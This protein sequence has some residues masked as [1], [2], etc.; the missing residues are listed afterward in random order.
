MKHLSNESL[1]SLSA[2]EYGDYLLSIGL[3]Y[4]DFNI[5]KHYICAIEYGDYSGLTDSDI[6]ALESWFKN[7]PENIS[8]FDYKDLDSCN[9]TRD[10][11]T[12]LRADCV[13]T[14]A[15]IKK[16]SQI[17]TNLNNAILYADSNR[18]VYIPQYFAESIDTQFIENLQEI[19][20]S[21]KDC[22]AGPDSESYWDSW[23][24]IESR[25][26][27]R[28]SSGVRLYIYQSEHGD[29]WLVPDNEESKQ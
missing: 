28:D 16:E 18:G 12:G 1:S 19:E 14:F 21:L 25:A 5:C 10:D 6:E 3:D 24:D 20:E 27:I 23:N 7:L 29:L 9:F 11:I 4:Y 13:T 22:K 17:M 26:I 2:S 15:I 8:H